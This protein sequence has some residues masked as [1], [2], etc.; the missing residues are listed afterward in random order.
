MWGLILKDLLL[1]KKTL[2]NMIAIYIG[3]LLISIAFG[4]YLLAICIVPLM[5]ISVGMTSFQNDEYN[6]QDVY[7]LTLPSSR[8]KIVTARYL[9][10]FLLIIISIYIG[11]LSYTFINFAVIPGIKY[12][13]SSGITSIQV[14]DPKF[15]GLNLDMIKQLLMIEASA[16]F[17]YSI[18]YPVIYKYGCEKSKYVLMSIVMVLLGILS[19]LSVYINVINQDAIDFNKIITFI[20]TNGL[21]CISLL[22]IVSTIV[23]YLLSIKFYK[24][25]DM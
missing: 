21:L 17:V 7:T 2:K 8:I 19:I 25:K 3:S 9:L 16:L 4:N 1:L 13:I 6:N 20:E 24:N 10:T 18:F 5:I 12:L 15:N 22:V 11:L 14:F 23:S